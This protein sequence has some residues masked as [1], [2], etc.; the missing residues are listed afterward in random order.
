MDTSYL[1]KVRLF[2]ELENQHSFLTVHSELTELTRSRSQN[3][4]LPLRAYFPSPYFP[5]LD[6]VLSRE[7]C[8][9]SVCSVHMLRG[10]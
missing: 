9:K 4:S 7:T 5:L 3:V 8:L 6:R 10:S 2:L 1:Y